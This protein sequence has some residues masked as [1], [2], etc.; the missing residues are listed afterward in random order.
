MGFVGKLRCC[1]C[2]VVLGV[3]FPGSAHAAAIASP[4]PALLAQTTGPTTTY[5]PIRGSADPGPAAMPA[6]WPSPRAAAPGPAAP[7][8]APYAS[9][10]AAPAP[11][12][13]V[14]VYVP[15]PAVQTDGSSAATATRPG[16]AAPPAAVFGSGSPVT[17]QS[18]PA[19]ASRMADVSSVTVA[20]RAVQ[21]P[22]PRRGVVGLSTD[23]GMPDGLNL[24][25]V[26]APASWLRLGASAG[27]NSAGFSYRGG[28]SLVPIGW[29][30]SLSFEAGHCN[31]AE[32]NSVLRTFF[33]VS[34]WV[35]PYVQQ[36]G[37]TY[38][39][40]HLGFD[41]P[42][43]SVMLFVHAGYTYLMGTVRG[44]NPVVVGTSNDA[45]KTPNMTVTIAQ[46][47]EV[48]AHTLSAKLGILYMF[49]GI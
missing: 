38:F 42:V 43:G 20:K 7:P 8:A 9:S 3:V 19:P 25:L 49:G 22:P 39:N 18:P 31:L 24:G 12:Q 4:L 29:G 17:A 16:L 2:L 27:T 40:A 32:M 45:A 36:F 10:P 34:S 11:L 1:S 14:P 30:P 37:Y 28:L 41:Y 15:I 33:S 5:S 35:K 21:L 46:D 26:L 48:R 47:G 44:S 13:Y 23:V 6:P